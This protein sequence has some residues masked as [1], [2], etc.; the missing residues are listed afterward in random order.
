MRPRASIT[1]SSTP[2]K[3]GQEDD[4]AGS[5]RPFASA[6]LRKRLAAQTQDARARI[7]PGGRRIEARWDDVG[8][9]HHAGAAATGVSSTARWRP[10]PC[11]RMS[12]VSSNHRPRASASPASDWP[13]GCW[14]QGKD[15]VCEHRATLYAFGRPL[16]RI[17]FGGWTSCPAP[18]LSH[19]V[20]NEDAENTGTRK[21]RHRKRL[22][23]LT[24]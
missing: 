17:I 15:R 8:A 9:H 19:Q 6:P 1:P 4:E 5:P 13:S 22:P 7:L 2:S 12:R 14:K 3:F 11:S 24:H 20:P 21:R 10:I 16:S 18:S 23:P